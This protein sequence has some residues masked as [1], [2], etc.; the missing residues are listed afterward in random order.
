MLGRIDRAAMR[1]AGLDRT[2]V[3]LIGAGLALLALALLLVGFP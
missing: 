1:R 3:A 2:A